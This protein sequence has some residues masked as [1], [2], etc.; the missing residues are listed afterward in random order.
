[1]I[2]LKTGPRVNELKLKLV[3]KNLSFLTKSEALK[4]V[5]AYTYIPL[6]LLG[7]GVWGGMDI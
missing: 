1:M 3:L 5:W 2:G 7:D 6:T 4:N